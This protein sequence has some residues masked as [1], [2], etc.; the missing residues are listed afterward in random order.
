MAMSSVNSATG[1]IQQQ[2]TSRPSQ[3]AERPRENQQAAVQ[4]NAAKAN[5]PQQPQRSE[6]VERPQAAQPV[7]NAQGQKTGSIINTTA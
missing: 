2:L 7:V 1:G 3:E 6:K 5:P 4:S